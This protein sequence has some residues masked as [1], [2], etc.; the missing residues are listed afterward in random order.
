[1]GC[2]VFGA[3]SEEATGEWRKP[4]ELNDLHFSPNI[5]QVIK[6]RRIR[7]AGHVGRMGDRRDGSRVLVGKPEGKTPLG[8]PG[9]DRGIILRWNLQ[10]VGCGDMDWIEVAQDKDR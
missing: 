9:V 2:I 1:M 10:E 4:H 3:R 7:W 5:V 8:D 6:L